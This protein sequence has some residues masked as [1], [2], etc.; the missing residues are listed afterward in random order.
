MWF[1]GEKNSDEERTTAAN[2]VFKK[3]L[4]YET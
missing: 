4:G 2:W 1:E 3:K